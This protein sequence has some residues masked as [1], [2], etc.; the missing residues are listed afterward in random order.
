MA[1]IINASTSTGLVQSADTSGQINIQSNVLTK[2]TEYVMFYTR[3]IQH[4]SN[5][6]NSIS[7]YCS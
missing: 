5:I 2:L 1:V 6:I 4:H 7:T 3:V